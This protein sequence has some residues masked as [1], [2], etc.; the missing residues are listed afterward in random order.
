MDYEQYWREHRYVSEGPVAWRGPHH[1]LPDPGF[2]TVCE[3]AD[4][5]AL[6]VRLSVSRQMFGPGDCGYRLLECLSLCEP[7]GKPLVSVQISPM[8][9]MRPVADRTLEQL[10]G[11]V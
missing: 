8:S 11:W 1:R 6:T 7:D 9:T 5:Q 4:R 10:E 3:A 2:V